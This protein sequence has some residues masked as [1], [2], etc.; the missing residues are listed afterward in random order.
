MKL[1]DQMSDNL[2]NIYL[3]GMSREAVIEEMTDLFA[4]DNAINSKEDFKQS[5]LAREEEASTGIGHEVAVPHG[6]TDAVLKSG[7]A[8]GRVSGGVDW[9]SHD[10]QPVKL[11]FMVAAPDE[12]QGEGHLEIMQMI[13]QKLRDESFKQKLLTVKT[14][15]EAMQLLK[16][17]KTE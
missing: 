14:N 13:S 7:V 2:V 10:G 17:I 6:K 1:I 9:N 15:E 11:I 16:E 12:E 8:F 5:L 4:E 3:E